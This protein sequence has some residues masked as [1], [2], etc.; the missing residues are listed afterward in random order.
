MSNLS[1][2]IIDTAEF[3]HMMR[4]TVEQFALAWRRADIDGL[5]SLLGSNPLYRTS[6]GAVFEGAENVRK[7]FTQICKPSAD[8]DAPADPPRLHFF[9]NKCVSY[10][11]L[12]I[13]AADGSQRVVEGVDILTFDERAKLVCKDAY[14]KLG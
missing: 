7:G 9:E 11:T 2:G 5:M 4:Q 6:A 1:A 12:L 3:T 10:W 13:S 14:R 8:N